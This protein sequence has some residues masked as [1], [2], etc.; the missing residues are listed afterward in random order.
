LRCNKIINRGEDRMS[1]KRNGLYDK[2]V[3]YI[4][5][6]AFGLLLTLMVVS[7]FVSAE[8]QDIYLRYPLTFF[9]MFLVAIFASLL[10]IYIATTE[11]R[12]FTS[13]SRRY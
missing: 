3:H 6:I 5:F 1:D 4:H 13:S 9:F 8:I 7:I 12:Q 11:N 10:V 2:E